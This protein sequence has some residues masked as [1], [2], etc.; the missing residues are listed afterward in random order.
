M[1]RGAYGKH[2]TPEQRHRAIELCL[3]AIESGWSITRFCRLAG[4]PKG[5]MNHWLTEDSV[6]DR[7]RRAREVQAML[8]PDMATDIVRRVIHGVQ[9]KREVNGKEV[10]VREFL[11]PKAAKVGLSHIEFR[12]MRE[13]KARMYAND[14]QLTVKRDIDDLS[15]REVV[16]RYEELERKALEARQQMQQIEGTARDVTKEPSDG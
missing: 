15:D 13:H 5:T 7:Y 8:L 12:L 9:V 4:V 16:A 14:R 2:F 1:A 10:L 6:F 11:D 3:R